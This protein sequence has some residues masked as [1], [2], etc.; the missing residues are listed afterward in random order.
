MK[1]AE[2]PTPPQ[3][4][5]S[6]SARQES[7]PYFWIRRTWSRTACARAVSSDDHHLTTSSLSK[8]TSNESPFE[9][10]TKHFWRR[11]LISCKVD[12]WRL[13]QLGTTCGAAEI[14][15]KELPATTGKKFSMNCNWWNTTPWKKKKQTKLIL[16]WDNL[17]G[18][19]WWG[20]PE[21]REKH[22]NS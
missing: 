1:D 15:A 8:Q 2:W 20:M 19:G 12:L 6:A 10:K 14:A 18:P 17:P 7:Q 5:V 11:C 9:K 13:D 3:V 22:Q 21:N 16:S 4:C